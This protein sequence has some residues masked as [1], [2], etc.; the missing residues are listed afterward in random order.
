MTRKKSL[1]TRNLSLVTD[2]LVELYISN[3]PI[4]SNIKSNPAC[5]RVLFFIRSLKS[6]RDGIRIMIGKCSFR[7]YGTK[8]RKIILAIGLD[9]IGFI[10]YDKILVDDPEHIRD[11]QDHIIGNIFK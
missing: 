2:L 6:K 9:K 7:I 8:L 1:V 4:I 5:S 3:I 11:I 10:F